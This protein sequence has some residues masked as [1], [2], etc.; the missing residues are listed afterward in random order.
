MAMYADRLGRILGELQ[1]G[2]EDE[3]AYRR[4][5]ERVGKVK[6][7][8]GTAAAGTV[9]VDVQINNADGTSRLI[10]DC[11]MPGVAAAPAID[12]VVRA[13]ATADGVHFAYAVGG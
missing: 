1:S 5:A 2:A 10:E 7:V 8:R 11:R 6:A 13:S 9:R 4:F 3:R 12:A